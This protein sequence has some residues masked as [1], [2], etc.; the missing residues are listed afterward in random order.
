[1]RAEKWK[2]GDDSIY[3]GAPNSYPSGLSRVEKALF[4]FECQGPLP[5]IEVGNAI[6]KAFPS[7]LELFE[8]YVEIISKQ[9]ITIDRT[10]KRSTDRL[11]LFSFSDDGK[12][13]G[14]VESRSLRL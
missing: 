6:Y 8:T 14:R 3:W 12:N 10:I 13:L 4:V 7:W 9:N 2:R 11:D 5:N 1:L